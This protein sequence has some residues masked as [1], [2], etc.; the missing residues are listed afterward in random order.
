VQL[1]LD[2]R[3]QDRLLAFRIGRVGHLAGPHPSDRATQ[4][5]VGGAA[6]EHRDHL[7][8]LNAP[9]VAA[10]GVPLLG[11]RQLPVR[12]GSAIAIVAGPV[13]D[14][15]T[16]TQEG[17]VGLVEDAPHDGIKQVHGAPEDRH[18]FRPLAGAFVAAGAKIAEMTEN[19][20]CSGR[21]I[22]GHPSIMRPA[23][24]RA[25]GTGHRIR[26]GIGGSADHA[27]AAADVHYL[28]SGAARA[29]AVVAADAAFSAVLAEHTATVPAVMPYRPGEFFLRELPPLRAVLWRVRGLGLVVVD[30]YVDLDADGRPGLGAHVRAEFGVPVIGVAKS[31]FRTAVHAVPVLRGRSARPLF[32]TA[33]GMPLADAAGLVRQMAGRF[34]LPDA[35]RRA[36]ALARTGQP[37]QA[38]LADG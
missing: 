7:Y 32:V 12:V 26:M 6:P 36:D 17:R 14:R 4:V 11:P 35:L 3:P 20:R 1:T 19:V 27:F 31:P 5:R 21:E 38:G 10:R 23:G 30:G 22:L 8:R 24:Q 13:V 15:A 28:R 29:A 37:G 16:A 33:A 2:D 34:R 25:R 9:A 18:P